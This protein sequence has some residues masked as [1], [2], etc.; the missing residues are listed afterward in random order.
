MSCEIW[1]DLSVIQHSLCFQCRKHVYFFLTAL[2]PLKSIYCFIIR[3]L[4]TNFSSKVHRNL[5]SE[6]RGEFLEPVISSV[7]IIFVNENHYEIESYFDIAKL[8]NCGIFLQNEA[9]LS[10]IYRDLHQIHGYQKITSENVLQSSQALT[11]FLWSI[12][13]IPVPSNFVMSLPLPRTPLALMFSQTRLK[14]LFII[15][16]N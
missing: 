3:L 13:S 7:Y 11:A 10:W 6:F 12:V 16:R 1:N 5:C 14:M 15:S 9:G 4:K 8:H 2:H